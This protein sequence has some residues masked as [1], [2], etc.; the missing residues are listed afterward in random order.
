MIKYN[1]TCEKCQKSFDSWFASS[2]EFEKLKKNSHFS[3][4]YCESKKIKKSIMSPNLPAKTNRYTKKHREAKKLKKK[5]IELRNYIEKNCE[6]VG[7]RFTHE[8]RSIHY[9]KKNS[10][11]IYGKAS[12]KETK[13]LLEEGIEIS[14][15]PW[16]DKNEN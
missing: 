13:E 4:I 5:L 7:D 2:K 6:Y 16:V 14:T 1:L 15:I 12:P 3:C 10:K 8:A 9:D 11:G